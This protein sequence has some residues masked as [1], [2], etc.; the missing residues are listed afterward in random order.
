MPQITYKD[1]KKQVK[2]HHL[3]VYK[4]E[5]YSLKAFYALMFK[6]NDWVYDTADLHLYDKRDKS[7]YAVQPSANATKPAGQQ[8]APPVNAPPQPTVLDGLLPGEPTDAP[9]LPNAQ[10]PDSTPPAEGTAIPQHPVDTTDILLNADSMQ[11]V[12]QPVQPPAAD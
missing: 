3:I 10:Q 4:D 5:F 7:T 11:Q 12:Q 9:V 6:V 1:L 2:A 8:P